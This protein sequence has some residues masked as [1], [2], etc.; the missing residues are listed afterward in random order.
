MNLDHPL[1]DC[2]IR[3]GTRLTLYANRLERQGADAMES[4]SLAHLASVRVAFERDP[5][6]LVWA[7]L[8]VVGALAL[9]AIAGPLQR[10]IAAAAVKFGDP[11]RSESLDALLHGVFNAL[12]SLANLLPAIAL[13]LAAGAVLL[14]V[15]FWLGTTTL[16]LAFAATERAHAVRGRDRRLVE[17]AELVCDRL[18]ARED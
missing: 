13:L 7:V 4:V 5:G 17:F 10:W 2:E 14:L 3:D 15:F 16:T 11:G 9:A 8:L 12:G 6:K 18:A 1:A